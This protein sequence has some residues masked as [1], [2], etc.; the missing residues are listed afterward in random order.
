M[1]G[2]GGE[3][4]R[5]QIPPATALA[6]VARESDSAGMASA[7]KRLTAMHLSLPARALLFALSAHEGQ[8]RKYTGEPYIT[9]PIV[10]ADLVATVTDRD[11]TIAVAYLHDVIEDTHGSEEL[12]RRAVLDTFGNEICR[13][14]D[15]LTDHFTRERY[16]QLNR[17]E[18]K[19]REVERLAT[20]S[21]AAKI[22][23]L[24]DV[25]ANTHDIA[26]QNAEPAHVYLA[27]KEAQLAVLLDGE[28]TL[29]ARARR[30]LDEAKSIVGGPQPERK[31]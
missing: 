17:A 24:A 18:R 26:R 29:V 16:P 27:E 25:I 3:G 14:V 31:P 6:L 8:R 12:A 22:V 21:P 7:A 23:K 11:E 20:V 9:H 10:V 2:D 5:A 19:R 13:L 15:E 1:G 28:P 4:A 30:T